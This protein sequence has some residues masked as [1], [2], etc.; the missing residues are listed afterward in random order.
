MRARDA[1]AMNPAVTDWIARTYP[2]AKVVEIGGGTGSAYLHRKCPGTY[3]IEHHPRWAAV[4][5]SDGLWHGKCNLQDG[6]YD[7]TAEA[8]DQ[9][10]HADVVVVDGPPGSLRNKIINHVHLFKPG[11]VVVFDDSHRDGIQKIIASL[12]GVGGWKQLHKIAEEETRTTTV[13]QVPIATEESTTL[14]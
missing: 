6:W 13:L 10:R 12:T 11:A 9:L 8:E 1:Y 14:A 5:R 7:L 2:S 4:L 3:T